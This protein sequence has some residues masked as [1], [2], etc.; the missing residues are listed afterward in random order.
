MR[1][2]LLVTMLL[3]A[4]LART[5]QIPI[6]LCPLEGANVFRTDG[7][8][9]VGATNCQ[10]QHDTDVEFAQCWSREPDALIP[11]FLV[12]CT[13]RASLNGLTPGL[14]PGIYDVAGSGPCAPGVA[15]VLTSLV[16]TRWWGVDGGCDGTGN[17]CPAPTSALGSVVG[18]S[19]AA[20]P[21]TKQR[22]RVYHSGRIHCRDVR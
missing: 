19:S 9:S 1:T 13:C 21:V 12:E 14:I 4:S 8:H 17:E 16:G 15:A 7:L 6:P 10:P 2:V 22:C 11:V 18:M 5:T 3:V 20:A